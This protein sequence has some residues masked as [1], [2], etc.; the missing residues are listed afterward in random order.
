MPLFPEKRK[1][2]FGSYVDLLT[3]GET[4]EA[5]EK[6]IENGTPTQHVV[7][8]VAKLAMMQ[9]D[10]RLRE[11]VNGCSLINAD[12]QGIVWGARS[13]GI[14]I[15]ERVAGVD[16]FQNLVAL[17]DRKPYRLYFLGAKEEVVQKVVSVFQERYPRMQ[18]AGRRNGYFTQAEEAQLVEDI[19][20]S[21]ADILFLAMSSPKKEY[22]LNRYLD[23]MQVPFV[24]GVG[25]SFDIV[26]GVTKRAPLWMQKAGLEWFYRI[27]NEPGRMFARYFTTNGKFF[28]MMLKAKVFG[29]KRYG[30]S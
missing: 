21:K 28:L 20:E 14:D 2:F 4:L 7:I 15:P 27:V 10:V 24:M 6:I 17:S 29:K 22:F 13:L 3:M 16:L 9:D 19:R 18:V 25:G 12:G 23:R 26:A 8:N 30:C 5:V 11:I 1:Q